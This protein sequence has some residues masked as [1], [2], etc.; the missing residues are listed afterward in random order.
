VLCNVSYV[1]FAGSPAPHSG[2]A[3]KFESPVGQAGRGEAGRRCIK[4]GDAAGHSCFSDVHE[5][6]RRVL[7]RKQCA[8]LNANTP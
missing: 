6:Q 1:E 2:G 3:I 5:G 8:P 7:F 4:S